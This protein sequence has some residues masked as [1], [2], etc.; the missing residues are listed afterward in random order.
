M[1]GLSMHFVSIFQPCH[2]LSPA[3]SSH[4][5][6][7]EL[8]TATMTLTYE[9]PPKSVLSSTTRLANALELVL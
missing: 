8:H 1:L 5:F 2:Q 4:R 6:N 7:L 3:L 9:T